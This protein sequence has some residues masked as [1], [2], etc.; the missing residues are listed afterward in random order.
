MN[1]YYIFE[2]KDSLRWCV[3][4]VPRQTIFPKEKFHFWKM[5]EKRSWRF[6]VVAVDFIWYAFSVSIIFNYNLQPFLSTLNQ[7][8]VIFLLIHF[9]TNYYYYGRASRIF[10]VCSLCGGLF[11][12]IFSLNCKKKSD[13]YYWASSDCYGATIYF[14]GSS[15]AWFKSR[16]NHRQLCISFPYLF[17]NKRIAKNK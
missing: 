1:S 12:W 15:N 10:N 14:A 13:V 9:P 7:I 2:I 4:T 3:Y 5:R 11:A 6:F 16:K 8:E 17:L